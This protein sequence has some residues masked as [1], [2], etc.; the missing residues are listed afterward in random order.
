MKE[1]KQKPSKEQKQ[2]KETSKRYQ[3]RVRAI[4][5]FKHI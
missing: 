1:P 5:D 2:S 3:E 4:R